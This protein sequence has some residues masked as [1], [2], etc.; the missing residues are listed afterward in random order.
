M[1]TPEPPDAELLAVLAEAQRLTAAMTATSKPD[2][3]P[4]R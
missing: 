2:Q 3:E 1:T 4:N